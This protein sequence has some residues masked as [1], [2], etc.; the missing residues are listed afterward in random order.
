MGLGDA[1]G[2][3]LEDIIGQIPDLIPVAVDRISAHNRWG[4]YDVPRIPAPTTPP[5]NGNARANDTSSDLIGYNDP[6]LVGGGHQL[7][8]VRTLDEMASSFLGGGSPTSQRGIRWVGKN[9]DMFHTTPCGHSRPNQI[10]MAAGA[11]GELGF[12]INAGKPKTWSK[13][14]IKKRRCSHRKR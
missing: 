4:K 14:S 9:E 2:D 3:A 7:Q 12:F 5:V 8:P 1:L 13:V 10:T 11:N 6:G